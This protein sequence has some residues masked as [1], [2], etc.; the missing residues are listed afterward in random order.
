MDLDE[1]LR[2]RT[3][4]QVALMGEVMWKRK[5]RKEDHVATAA[6]WIERLHKIYKLCGGPP[7]IAS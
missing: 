6:K 3:P 4:E 2:H 5:H 7:E 1:F